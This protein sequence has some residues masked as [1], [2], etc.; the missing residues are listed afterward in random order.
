MTSSRETAISLGW[1]PAEERIPVVGA[2]HA[3]NDYTFVE[4]LHGPFGPDK[5]V[6][7]GKTVYSVVRTGRIGHGGMEEDTGGGV[8]A[9]CSA[10]GRRH[11]GIGA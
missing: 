5:C 2:V 11:H 3:L 4:T 7:C 6:D 1:P 9:R 10:C 8:A